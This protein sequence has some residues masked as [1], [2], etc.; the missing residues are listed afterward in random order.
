MQGISCKQC[1]Q[2]RLNFQNTQTAHITQKQQK[3]QQKS[4]N[5]L[6]QKWADLNRH[7]PKKTY[8]WPIS[9]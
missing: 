6:I 3:N 8:R 9:T 5:N 1:D 4:T 7:F 2:Q